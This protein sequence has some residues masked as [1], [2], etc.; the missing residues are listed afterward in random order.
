[1]AKCSVC[2]EWSRDQLPPQPGSNIDL[3]DWFAGM[4]MQ[5][6]IWRGEVKNQEL[7]REAFS[8]SSMMMTERAKNK[9]L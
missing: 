1:M 5:A 9:A 6:L 7:I 4:A 3:R 2:G 8:T